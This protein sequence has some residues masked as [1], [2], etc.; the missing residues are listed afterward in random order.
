[1]R[2]TL[3]N[4][5]RRADEAEGDNHEQPVGLPAGPHPGFP[6]VCINLDRQ[7]IFV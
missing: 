1:M 2:L 5:D 7:N 6:E 3:R 4:G